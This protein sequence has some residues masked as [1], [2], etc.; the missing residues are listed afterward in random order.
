[1]AICVY[2][3][4][5]SRLVKPLGDKIEKQFLVALFK[6]DEKKILS[7]FLFEWND[8]PQTKYDVLRLQSWFEH[9]SLK[10]TR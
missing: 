8:L 10:Q 3:L 5:N 9:C 4:L 6:N 2:F 1:M 7:K